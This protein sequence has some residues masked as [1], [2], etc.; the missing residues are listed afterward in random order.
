MDHGCGDF[1]DGLATK[2]PIG[3]FEV[4]VCLGQRRFGLAFD[5][6]FE[7]LRLRAANFDQDEQILKI[8]GLFR[9]YPWPLGF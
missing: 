2:V 9:P 7:P 3:E 5:P 1:S 8:A 4:V 6:V